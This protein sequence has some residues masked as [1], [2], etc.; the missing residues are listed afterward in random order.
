MLP[1]AATSLRSLRSLRSLPS[2]RSLRS[3]RKLSE[4]PPEG[5]Q[6]IA[7]LEVFEILL[8]AAPLEQDDARKNPMTSRGSP[9][10]TSTE[11]TMHLAFKGEA[12]SNVDSLTLK[13]CHFQQRNFV[14][15]IW[16]ASRCMLHESGW[17]TTDQRQSTASQCRRKS[18]EVP[19]SDPACAESH[20]DPLLRYWYSS[21]SRQV[22]LT[23]MLACLPLSK[24]TESPAKTRGFSPCRPD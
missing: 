12:A 22:L 3:L 2:L 24:D 7:A 1:L 19:D 8:S 20:D 21:L 9:T 14:H 11:T 18:I 5:R 4:K 23:A 13:V 17:R 6:L 16:D 15:F 10:D